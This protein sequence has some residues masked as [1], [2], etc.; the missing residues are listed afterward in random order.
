MPDFSVPIKS[1]LRRAVGIMMHRLKK[2]HPLQKQK[3]KELPP[4]LIRLG[5]EY[6]GW[7]FLDDPASL[8]NS[9]IVSAGLGEDASFDIEFANKYDAKVLVVDPT[10]RAIIHFNSI[11]QHIGSPRNQQYVKGGVQ[12]IDAYDL[13]NIKNDQLIL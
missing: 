2:K 3:F 5:S 10:P 11:N 7:C 12:P 4:N 9:I 13:E 8:R 1:L 6:G